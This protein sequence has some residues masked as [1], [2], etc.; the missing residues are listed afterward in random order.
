MGNAGDS[1]D[2]ALDRSHDFLIALLENVL[3]TL[4]EVKTKIGFAMAHM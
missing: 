1:I 3:H 4:D 2:Q